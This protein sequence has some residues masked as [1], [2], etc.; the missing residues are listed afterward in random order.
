[1]NV[2]LIDV[3]N[4][5]NLKGCFPNLAMMKLS[6]WHKQNGDS[7]EWYDP[8]KALENV[9]RGGTTIRYMPQKYSPFHRITSFQFM[10]MM[11]SMVARAIVY[12][13]DLTERNTITNQKTK[14][15]RMR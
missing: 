7:V 14:C 6:A 13:W 12:R 5:K 8:M 2:G 10:Q 1:M 4:Y 9:F 11:L 3:D 15:F